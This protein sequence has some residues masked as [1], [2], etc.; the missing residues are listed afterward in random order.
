MFATP[1]KSGMLFPLRTGVPGYP[2][3]RIPQVPSPVLHFPCCL[4]IG[5]LQVEHP[6]I[7]LRRF[8]DLNSFCSAENMKIQP[9]HPPCDSNPG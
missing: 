8:V 3:S 6:S 2:D 7:P 5:T 1:S 4:Q 9:D